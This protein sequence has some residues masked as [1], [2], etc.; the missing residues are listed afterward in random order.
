MN[1]F[2]LSSIGRRRTQ[3]ATACLFPVFTFFALWLDS[4]TFSEIYFEGQKITT[5]ASILYFLVMFFVSDKYLRKLLFTMVLLSYIGELIFCLG[6]G[7]YQYRLSGIPL[8]VPFGH[9]IVFG[10]GYI[11]ST[12]SFLKR[13][14]F[15]MNKIFK[16]LFPLSFLV[17]G[18]YFEDVFTL[19]FGSFFMFLIKR[20][21]WQSVYF[22]IALCV[23]YIE[24][25]GTY[26]GCWKW[27]PKVFSFI[28]TENPPIGAVFFYAGGD[29]LLVK[30]V[31]KFSKK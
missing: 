15:N 5:I 18:V 8:Y 7:M 4:T 25:V 24:L 6:L 27:T 29:V 20:K 30:I 26:F 2:N 14:D 23:I 19:I 21:N 13:I 22:Y 11:F 31:S 10:S 3:I 1:T 17:V 9:A 12:L 16:W 28:L